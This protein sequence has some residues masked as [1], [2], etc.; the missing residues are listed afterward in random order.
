MK[1]DEAIQTFWA[2]I[3]IYI[4]WP[5]SFFFCF[6]QQQALSWWLWVPW[7]QAAATSPWGWGWWSPLWLWGRSRGLLESRPLFWWQCFPGLVELAGARFSL[8]VVVFSLF[9]VTGICL[10]HLFC[11]RWNKLNLGL[12]HW[13]YLASNKA[14]LS[15]WWNVVEEDW[16]RFSVAVAYCVDQHCY[17]SGNWGRPLAARSEHM[18]KCSV[19]RCWTLN[20]SWFLRNSLRST[21]EKVSWLVQFVQT[22][23]YKHAIYLLLLWL[24]FSE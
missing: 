20:C 3:A 8:Q 6:F 5:L 21:M 12:L 16:W 24:L 19:I 7:L 1:S 9:V 18:E 10:P 13:Q 23:A 11:V 15:D 14:S 22:A 4:Q 2:V 17:R